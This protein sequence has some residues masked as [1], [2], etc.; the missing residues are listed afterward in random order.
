MSEA[1]DAATTTTTTTKKGGGEGE[2]QPRQ[3]KRRELRQ[4][5]AE[6]KLEADRKAVCRYGMHELLLSISSHIAPIPSLHISSPTIY[7]S[8]YPSTF[9]FLCPSIHTYIYTHM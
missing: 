5:A 8:T 6:A 9:L 3:K 7:V 1:G 2:Q 4:E